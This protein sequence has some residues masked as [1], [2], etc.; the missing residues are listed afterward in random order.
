[1]FAALIQERP[2]LSSSDVPEGLISWIQVAGGF[3]AVGLLIWLLTALVRRVA[4]PQGRFAPPWWDPFARLLHL[5]DPQWSSAAGLDRL[6]LRALPWLRRL[7][8]LGL[9]L[10]AIAYLPFVLTKLPEVFMRFFSLFTGQAYVPQEPSEFL[11]SL[12]NASLVGGGL[13]ALLAAGLPFAVDLLY[14]RTRRIGAIARLTIKEVV[15][16]RVLWVFLLLALVF[17]FGTWFIDPKPEN[18]VRSYVQV[19]Y[20]AMAILLLLTGSLLAAFSIPTDVRQQTIHTIVTKPVQ[21]YEIFL[22]RY[23]GY[24]TVMT[25]ALLVMTSFSLIYVRRGVDP[26]AVKESLKARVPVTGSLRYENTPD[27]EKGENVGAEWEYRGYIA[28]PMPGQ[29]APQYAIWTF[30]DLPRHL[31]NRTDRIPC[32]FTFA[33]Y[34]TTTGEINK[35]VFCSFAVESWL[36]D[37]ARK[38]EYSAEK[39]R[40]R[41]QANRPSDEEIDA[42]LADTYGYYEMPSKEVVNYHTLAIELPAAVFKNHFRSR[43]ELKPKLAALGEKQEKGTLTAQEATLLS[44][45]ERDARGESRAPLQVRV[46]CISRTQFLGMARYDLYLLDHEEPFWVNFFKGV[47]GI[48]MWMC[49]VVG[50]ALACSTYL[51]GVISWLCVV[52]LFVLGL[53][54]EFVIKVALGQNDGGGPAES[55]LRLLGRQNMLTPLEQTTVSSVATGSDEV[56]RWV[57]RGLIN[58]FPDVDRFDFSILVANGFD[59]SAGQ[60]GLTLLLLLAY[61][62]PWAVLA[63]YLIKSREIATW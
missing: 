28:G 58:I 55:V 36:W 43:E 38:A 7:F 60:I 50:L 44:R 63:Y 39:V 59:V 49:L 13:C 40:L 30:P 19:V 29:T 2:P 32:E 41:K 8:V 62:L 53:A 1:M 10:A 11:G 37:P 52:F 33:I 56:Y 21:R 15:R 20:L 18:Q 22:G 35:G 48:W 51:N 3:A 26:D 12:L 47:V 23:L 42:Q 61:Y 25:V 34:R 5:G 46:R 17:L 45:L 9:L 16:R 14:L 4:L 6:V 27:P 24:I 54:R 57:M 31:S